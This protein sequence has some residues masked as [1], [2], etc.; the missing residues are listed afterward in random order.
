MFSYSKPLGIGTRARLTAAAGILALTLGGLLTPATAQATEADT[1]AQ[2]DA[3]LA[4]QP[5]DGEPTGL[6][7][8]NLAV[9]DQ[10]PGTAGLDDTTATVDTDVSST[11]DPTTSID[12]DKTSSSPNGDAADAADGVNATTNEESATDSIAN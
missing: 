9:V 10:A 3:L 4:T 7:D 1:S 12:T 6:V 5:L 2:T 8:D 11:A